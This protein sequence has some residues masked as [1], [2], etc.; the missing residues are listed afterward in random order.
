[1]PYLLELFR[2]CN[3]KNS[4]P[5]L[6][7]CGMD[8]EALIDFGWMKSLRVVFRWLPLTQVRQKRWPLMESG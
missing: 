2:H 1:M 8:T 4:L 6:I 3:A 7:L 5:P